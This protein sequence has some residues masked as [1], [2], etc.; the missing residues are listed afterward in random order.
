MQNMS[1]TY[2]YEKTFMCKSHHLKHVYQCEYHEI[3][4]LYREI[5][6]KTY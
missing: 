6:K 4:S 5:K 3:N 1:K 2:T